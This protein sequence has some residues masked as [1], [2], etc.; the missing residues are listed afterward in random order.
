MNLATIINYCTNDYRFIGK[1][2]A[3]ARKFSKQILIPVCDHFFDG[4]PEN[5]MLLEHT[6]A[7][8]PDCQFI[9]FVYS[10]ERLYTPY[11]NL[12]SADEAWIRM[13]HSTARYVGFLH[14]EPQI[15]SVLFLDCDE[16]VEGDR[17]SSWLKEG[18][19]QQWNAMRLL[20]YYYVL[21]PDYRATQVQ[22]LSL[23]VRRS[24]LSPHFFHHPDERYALYRYVPEPKREQGRHPD[25]KP[26]IHHYSWVRPKDEC[27]HKAATWG[28]RSDADWPQLIKEAFSEKQGS[29]LFGTD[30]DFEPIEKP[31]FDPLSVPVPCSS[32]P[33]QTF[34]HVK[35]VNKRDIFRMELE[36]VYGD[37]GDH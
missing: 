6:Y 33:P 24:V 19:W 29:R 30:L 15:D 32:L 4:A 12:T 1:C 35:K 23:L 8:H 25:G 36:M 17:F 14:L 2:I 31:Y 28:H 27:L 7:E 18:Q 5:R 20:C 9:E 3:E 26:M 37:S 34:P 22:D 16:I 13:W 21:R 10:S 11:S